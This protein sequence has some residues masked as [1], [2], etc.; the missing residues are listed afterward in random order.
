MSKL[1]VTIFILEVIE[2]SLEYQWIGQLSLL[3]SYDHIILS[4]I[5]VPKVGNLVHLLHGYYLYLY[6]TIID[7]LDS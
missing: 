2:K 5:L 6:L 4:G 7:V 3:L 1:M